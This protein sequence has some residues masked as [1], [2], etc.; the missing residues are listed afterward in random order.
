MIRFLRIWLVFQD[1]VSLGSP[2]YLG[3]PSV[4][5]AEQNSD[6]HLLLPPKCWDERC[7]PPHLAGWYKP[8]STGGGGG[9][10]QL[11]ERVLQYPWNII[12][13]TASEI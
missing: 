1:N 8:L 12:S 4:D 3:A 7:A 2:G 13:T 10:I 11:N 6:I 5:Q 9:K